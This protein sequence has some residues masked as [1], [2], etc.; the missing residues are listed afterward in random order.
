MSRDINV[1]IDD[2]LESVA[3]IR[4]YTKG[5]SEKDFY[6]DTQLQDSVLRRLE[7]IGEA[8]K[9]I[10]DEIREQYPNIPWKQIAG[11]RDILIHEYFGVNLKRIWK[12]VQE[13]V[14]TLEE[15][16]NRLKKRK[17]GERNESSQTGLGLIGVLLIIG[18]LVITAGGVLVWQ[19]KVLPT[20][21]VP[22]RYQPLLSKVR[23][24]GGLLV[25]VTLNIP[26]QPEGEL[27]NEEARE[28]QRAAVVQA[29]DDLLSELSSFDVSTYAR[30][31]SVPSM[32][33]VVDEE[34]LRYLIF[35]PKVKS[36]QEDEPVPPTK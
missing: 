34:A 28:K 26:W 36:I 14:D 6:K 3:K 12:V 21:T 1:Y 20:P 10:P 18:A 9:N 31:E 19:K 11:M 30:W 35:S 15:Q 8:V 17:Q 7:I 16:V 27:P 2:I 23:E 22:E 13:D 24:R 25:I 33:L 32:G 4:E 5:V 29:Q